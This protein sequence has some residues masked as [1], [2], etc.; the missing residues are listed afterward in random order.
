ML[1]IYFI[2]FPVQALAHIILR[3]HILKTETK[4]Q[5]VSDKKLRLILGIYMEFKPHHALYLTF[6][7]S[8]VSQIMGAFTEVFIIAFT[9]LFP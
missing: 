9:F 7:N 1:V 5:N 2:Q 6:L 4:S 8:L 3:S